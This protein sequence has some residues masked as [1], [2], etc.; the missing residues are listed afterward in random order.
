MVDKQCEVCGFTWMIGDDHC[1]Q[2]R[3]KKFEGATVKAQ[4]EGCSLPKARAIVESYCPKGDRRVELEFSCALDLLI[5]VVER[6]VL[7]RISHG[8]SI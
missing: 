6:D 1:R 5:S 4:A 3:I 7:R 2:C 8:E